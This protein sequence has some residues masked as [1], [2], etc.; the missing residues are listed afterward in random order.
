VIEHIETESP[1]GT[2]KLRTEINNSNLFVSTGYVFKLMF[3]AFQKFA[4]MSTIICQYNE[5]KV[6]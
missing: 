1:G 3:T 2:L 5:K 6:V 4:L